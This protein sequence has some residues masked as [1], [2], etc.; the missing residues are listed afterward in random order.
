MLILPA[1][2]VGGCAGVALPTRLA[3]LRMGDDQQRRDAL[4]HTAQGQAQGRGVEGGKALVEDDDI[5]AL[6][7]GA[8]EVETALLAVG[9]APA[10]VA[11]HLSRLDGC[12]HPIDK[13]FESH[14]GRQG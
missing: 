1:L 3:R 14:L 8:S 13:G 5:G 10:G 4:Q 9:E 6:Q 12:Y 7:H 2:G 11:D